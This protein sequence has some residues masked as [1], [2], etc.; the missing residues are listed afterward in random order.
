LVEKI[1][2]ARTLA[3][4]CGTSTQHHINLLLSRAFSADLSLFS[5]PRAFALGFPDMSPLAPKIV[6]W[7][8]S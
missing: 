2:C 6:L 7:P 8:L 3:R 5:R 1:K 4:D